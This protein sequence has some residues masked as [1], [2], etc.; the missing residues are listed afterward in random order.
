MFS[1]SATGLHIWWVFGVFYCLPQSHL[2]TTHR[3][4][5]WH[6]LCPALVVSPNTA[7]V[8][9]LDQGLGV[10]EEVAVGGGGAPV[11]S[12]EGYVYYPY[13]FWPDI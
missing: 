4:V 10:G 1:T 6:L 7:R 2:F 8:P 9:R 13:T 11:L 3:R 5:Q 12:R